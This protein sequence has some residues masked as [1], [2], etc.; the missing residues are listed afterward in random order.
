MSQ[1]LTK[2]YIHTTF[3]TKGRI[4]LLNEQISL[5]L[6]SYIGSICNSLECYAVKIGGTSNHIHILNLLSKKITLI[7]FIEEIKKS[8]SK[9]LKTK[10]E[11]LHNFYWQNG[12]GSFSVNPLEIDVVIR[13]I[14]NQREHH[15]KHTFEEEFL[16]FLKKYNVEYDERFVWD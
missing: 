14:D 1:S 9:W 8:S 3:S 7:K 2:I 4:H 12:Y 11:K 16:A 5:E 10:D 6:Y 15:K 13:Y